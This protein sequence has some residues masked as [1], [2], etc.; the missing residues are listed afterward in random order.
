MEHIIKFKS[1]A[2]KWVLNVFL[3]IFFIVFAFEIIFGVFINSYYTTEISKK[4]KEY[5]QSF[6]SSIKTVLPENLEVTAKDYCEKFEHKDKM[7]LQVLN[8]EGNVLVSTSG[9]EF[10]PSSMPDF[11]KARKEYPDVTFLMVNAPVDAST[12]I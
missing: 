5:A 4:S 10:T 3:V 6:V 11:E 7:E 12:A 1:V 9:F 8:A 2:F